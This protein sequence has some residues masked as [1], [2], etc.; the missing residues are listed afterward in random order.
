MKEANED[1]SSRKGK[2]SFFKKIKVK[3]AAITYWK[4]CISFGSSFYKEGGKRKLQMEICGA[5][6]IH[7][8]SYNE[9]SSRPSSKSSLFLDLFLTNSS[10]KSSLIAPQLSL[11]ILCHKS[12]TDTRKH[13]NS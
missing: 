13:K 11:H 5:L 2:L 10:T 3:H 8:F 9:P 4:G 7:E 1:E 6:T 12:G